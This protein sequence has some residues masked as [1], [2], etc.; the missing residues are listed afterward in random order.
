MIERCCYSFLRVLYDVERRDATW[1]DLRLTRLGLA[2]SERERGSVPAAQS[3]KR[4]TTRTSLDSKV[5]ITGV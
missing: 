5:S 4:D 1:L 2:Y 3:E